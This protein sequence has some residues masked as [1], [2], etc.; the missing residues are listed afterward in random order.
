MK[1]KKHIKSKLKLLEPISTEIFL[2]THMSRKI[3]NAI[4]SLII[5]DYFIIYL[6]CIIYI[7]IYM[8]YEI[9]IYIDD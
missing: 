8:A 9:G 5:Y 6:L 4:S 2:S 1:K 7:Y 3:L